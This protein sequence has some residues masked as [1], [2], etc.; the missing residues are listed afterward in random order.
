MSPQKATAPQKRPLTIKGANHEPIE[1]PAGRWYQ[2]T[3]D[4]AE[5]MCV[6]S[7]SS[8]ARQV[9]AALELATMG[10]RQELAVTMDG[11][12]KRALRPRDIAER[13][14]LDP[15]D[16]AHG[17]TEL[18][19]AGLAERRADDGG[20]LRQGHV[21]L[22]SFAVPRKVKEP[23]DPGARARVEMPAWVDSRPDD[24]PLKR[25]VSRWK[26]SFSPDV[27]VARSNIEAAEVAARA[28]I[29]AENLVR[30]ALEGCGA[31]FPHI[32]KKEQKERAE[33]KGGGGAVSGDLKETAS[34]SSS[35]VPATTTTNSHADKKGGH[36]RPQPLPESIW[37]AAHELT[38][39]TTFGR[40]QVESYWDRCQKL[41]GDRGP[42]SPQEVIEIMRRTVE[43]A[44]GAVEQFRYFITAA[45]DQVSAYLDHRAE[46]RAMAAGTRVSRLDRFMRDLD[47]E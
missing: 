11:G 31:Q 30:A 42:L 43:A 46:P 37:E 6:N 17:F 45:P 20:A 25:F 47:A 38:A 40:R 32:R 12:K 23:A 24:D 27:V 35:S 18:V 9:H 26:I 41:A 36:H 44:G 10:F 14:G 1:I 5:R 22:Y 19:R 21:R 7:L 28:M 3:K 4:R 39:L 15:T 34:S 33:R 16:V 29:E 2:N 13:T 8:K